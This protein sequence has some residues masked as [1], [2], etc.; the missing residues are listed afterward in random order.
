MSFVDLVKN[1]SSRQAE[2]YKELVEKL[3]KSLHN[4]S[5]NMSIMVYFLHSHL[6]KF[7][8]NCREVSD[9]Q[10]KQF[11]QDIKTMEEGCHG[12]WDK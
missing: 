5:I 10:G 8:D 11:H 9:E 4:I 7:P 12:E 1:L 6:N 3:L 2:N